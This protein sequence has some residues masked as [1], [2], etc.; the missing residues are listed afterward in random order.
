MSMHAL[1]KALVMAERA[2]ARLERLDIAA[3]DASA[4]PRAAN[5][6]GL[7]TRPAVRSSRRLIID[8]ARLEGR[9][10]ISPRRPVSRLSEELRL[11]K[12]QVLAAAFPPEPSAAAGPNGAPAGNALAV[13]SAVDG[14]GKTFIAL[15]LAISL[16]I[17]CDTHVLLV[18]GDVLRPAL[19]DLLGLESGLGLIDVLQDP[20]LDLGTAI[21][22]TNIPK[23]SLLPAGRQTAF[24]AELL[25]SR[26]MRGLMREMAGRYPDRMIIFD[27]PPLLAASDSAVLAHEAGQ[28]LIVVEAGRTSEA[29][30]SS[31]LAMVDDCPNVALLLNKVSPAVSDWDFGRIY[32]AARY[33]KPPGR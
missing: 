24:S 5:D 18:D 10:L 21:A 2:A 27:S 32:R 31:A 16:A 6:P 4:R 22:A 20:T 14:E 33:R 17:D 12:R 30:L 13:T 25:G 11:I 28:V 23:L 29:T 26:R 15:N 8:L 9:G 1:E 7:P 19:F 3:G